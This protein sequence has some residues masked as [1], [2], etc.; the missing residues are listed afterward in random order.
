VTAVLGRAM[1]HYRTVILTM[2]A[3]GL[4]NAAPASGSCD[5]VLGNKVYR[6]TVKRLDD[7]PAPD[8]VFVDCYRF[9]QPGVQ[10]LHFDVALDQL[11]G[12]VLSCGCTS[13]GKFGNPKFNQ[14]PEFQ[15]VTSAASPSGLGLALRGK[16]VGN[17]IKKGQGV[18]DIGWLF[19][20]ECVQDP[21][22]AAAASRVSPA[23]RYTIR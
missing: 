6:C 20:F 5:G 8:D 11:G 14:G 3:L 19:A 2:L 23:A 17:K 7:T 22:C 21:G 4:V 18:N 15:C 10:S 12:E 1:A 9:Q 16:P 13:K